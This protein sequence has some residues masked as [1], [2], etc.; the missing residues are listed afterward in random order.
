MAP[1]KAPHRDGGAERQPERRGR[2]DGR[3]A[4]LQRQQHDLPEVRLGKYSG[5]FLHMGA[6]GTLCM[7]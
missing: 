5:E 2:R 4:H 1:R 7:V 3:E 6:E